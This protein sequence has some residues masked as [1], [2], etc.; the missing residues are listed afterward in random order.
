MEISVV[1]PAYNEEESIRGT[2]ARALEALRPRFER[3]EIIIVDDCGR[4]ATGRIADELAAQHPEIVVLHN[5]HNMGQ[6][7]SILRGF[8][9]ARYELVTHNAMDYPMDLDDLDRMMPLLAEAEIVVAFRERR[10]G[11]SGYRRIISHLNVALLHLFF[12][13]HLRDYNFIQIYPKS[14]LDGVEVISRS[15]GFVTPELL[16]RAH[17][18]GLRV[19][20][21]EVPYQARVAGVATAGNPRIVLASFKDLMRFWWLRLWGRAKPAPGGKRVR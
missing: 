17:D 2:I 19:K 8:H 18:M 14:Y 10:A 20:E 4:D 9:Q 1:F 6:A 11:Y 12:D 7:E 5:P 13:L 15:A 21:I 16:F 3:F